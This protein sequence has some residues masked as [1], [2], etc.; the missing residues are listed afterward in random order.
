MEMLSEMKQE[1]NSRMLSHPNKRNS[2]QKKIYSKYST[3]LLQNPSNKGTY[4]RRGPGLYRSTVN[5][6]SL[7]QTS[8]SLNLLHKRLFKFKPSLTPGLG[9][10]RVVSI[11][12]RQD[13][14]LKFS[15]EPRLGDEAFT[16]W[17]NAVRRMARI[18]DGLP[19]A[20]RSRVWST[21]ADRQLAKQHVDW[22]HEIK[23]AFNEPSNQDDD[24]LGEQIVK[25]LHRTGC[26]QFGSDSDRA[27]LKR[28]LLAYAR[29]NKRVGY[30]QGFNVIAAGVLDVTGRD[31]KKAF[32]CDHHCSSSGI[33]CFQ[34]ISLDTSILEIA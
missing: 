1:N 4:G 8:L 19:S 23:M 13:P 32:K 7:E 14:N 10:R 16:E 12:P 34:T 22:D 21:L 24:R 11:N 33:Y 15:M 30:C 28:V 17:I 2:Q 31:E 5:E 9:T 20:I 26:E 27:S 18:G 25:D 6:L 3:R 29:W